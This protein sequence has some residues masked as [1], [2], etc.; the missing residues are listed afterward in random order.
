MPPIL[1]AIFLIAGSNSIPARTAEY[2]ALVE[3]VLDDESAFHDGDCRAEK[4]DGP[5]MVEAWLSK[6]D[7]RI[8]PLLEADTVCNKKYL[9]VDGPRR[10][11]NKNEVVSVI[12]IEFSRTAKDRYNYDASQENYTPQGGIGSSRC[13]ALASGNITRKGKQWIR[14]CDGCPPR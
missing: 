8:R 12:V 9:V 11:R 5:V 4:A 3:A 7:H 13:G 1:L 2:C 6:D 10:A 14:H